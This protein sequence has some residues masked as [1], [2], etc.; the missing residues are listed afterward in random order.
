MRGST[1]SKICLMAVLA[2]VP[3]TSSASAQSDGN[4][5]M[6]VTVSFGA[7][8]NTAVGINPAN[9][10]IL[11]TTIE[12]KKAGVV[13]FVVAGFH[14]IFIYLPGTR[15]E[16]IIP[17]FPANLFINEFNN[18]YYAGINPAGANPIPPP[19]ATTP[20]AATV[21]NGRNRTESV[22]FPEPG[23]YL[24]ICNVAP[25]FIDGMWAW[26]KVSN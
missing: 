17:N 11:P 16:D 1:V 18:L 23:T 14:Q 12:I 26:V 8:L 19:T 6:S 24:V 4:S 25:H 9:H 7:G 5:R 21:F 10:H 20:P 22:S 13:N 15:P 2:I 3:L